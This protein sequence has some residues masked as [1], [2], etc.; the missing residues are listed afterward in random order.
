MYFPEN[1]FSMLLMDLSEE[2]QAF[3]VGGQTSELVST[4]TDFSGGGNNTG[5]NSTTYNGKKLPA[6][7]VPEAPTL[8][9]APVLGDAPSF[10]GFSGGFGLDFG[11][12]IPSLG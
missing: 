5:S 11:F 8:G 10:S 9:T 6:S 4:D 12:D 7:L 3:V 1:S 2:Q